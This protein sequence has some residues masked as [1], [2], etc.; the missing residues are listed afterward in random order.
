[1]DKISGGVVGKSNHVMV[2]LALNWSLLYLF[3]LAQVLFVFLDLFFLV[4]GLILA[5]LP[6]ILVI[7]LDTSS[8]SAS[9]AAELG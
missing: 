4:L 2:R 7:F 9:T 8:V 3:Y 5:I 1:M 6:L